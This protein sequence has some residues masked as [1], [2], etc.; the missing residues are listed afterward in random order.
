MFKYTGENCVGIKQEGNMEFISWALEVSTT[1]CVSG[2][3]GVF[4]V[5]GLYILVSWWTAKLLIIVF[6]IIIIIIIIIPTL[7]IEKEEEEEERGSENT[8]KNKIGGDL[9]QFCANVHAH[10]MDGYCATG[11]RIKEFYHEIYPS[12]MSHEWLLIYRVCVCVWCT[13]KEQ[14]IEGFYRSTVKLLKF[15]LLWVI[16]LLSCGL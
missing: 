1:V 14:V 10:I 7:I 8:E 16:N 5:S 4:A 9:G 11:N 13:L 2:W 6:N 3:V 12:G 15:T